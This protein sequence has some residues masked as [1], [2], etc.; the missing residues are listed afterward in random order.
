MVRGDGKFDNF[1]IKD[2]FYSELEY[3]VSSKVD[4]IGRW[5]G[6]RRIGNVAANS[7]LSSESAIL[8]YTGTLAY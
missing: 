1:F 7:R 5:D 3:P 2:C 6:M 8:R 4:L